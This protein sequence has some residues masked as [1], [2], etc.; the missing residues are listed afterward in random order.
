MNL[1]FLVYYLDL[2]KKKFC[3]YLK[4]KKSQN[5]LPGRGILKGPD[6]IEKSEKFELLNR[7][8]SPT[9]PP[10]HVLFHVQHTAPETFLH[11]HPHH[12]PL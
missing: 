4:N 9:H 7:I 6:F 2:C 8:N 11:H 3:Y 12:P 10:V 5:L 1:F